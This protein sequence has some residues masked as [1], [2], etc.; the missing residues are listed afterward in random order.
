[1]GCP[2][3]S[4]PLAGVFGGPLAKIQALVADSATYEEMSGGTESYLY[5]RAPDNEFGD[6]WIELGYAAGD[7]MQANMAT[8]ENQDAGASG[9]GWNRTIEL[10]LV[11]CTEFVN[12]D[13]KGA[14]VNLA[15]VIVKEMLDA[16]STIVIHGVQLVGFAFSGD[17]SPNVIGA[18]VQLTL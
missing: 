1:M 16:D 8:R 5:R 4:S 2:Y 14:L 7:R 18:T 17:K 15:S 3:P 13:D 11:V 10:N 6:I 12:E 9:F